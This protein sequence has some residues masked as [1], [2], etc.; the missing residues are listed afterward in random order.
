MS[1]KG[2][3]LAKPSG[4]VG[5]SLAWRTL[6]CAYMTTDQA[7]L[8]VECDLYSRPGIWQGAVELP[9]SQVYVHQVSGSQ[10]HSTL[11]SFLSWFYH[12]TEKQ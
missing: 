5:T 2:S 4:P 11:P 1:G 10:T 8:C 9:K 6:F 3:L 12:P 7:S